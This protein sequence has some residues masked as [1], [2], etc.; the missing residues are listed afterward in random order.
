MLIR[1]NEALD[2]N[3]S[4]KHFEWSGM[5]KCFLRRKWKQSAA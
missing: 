2:W 4:M 1:V 3:L 5:A